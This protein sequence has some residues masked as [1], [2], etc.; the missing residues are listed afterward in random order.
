MFLEK[1]RV[2]FLYII[3]VNI[4]SINSGNKIQKRTV[5][6]IIKLFIVV[7]QTNHLTKKWFYK[8]NATIE[9]LKIGKTAGDWFGG[10]FV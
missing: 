8:F 4:N 10:E 1:E 3:K 6:Y 9:L 2:L 7:V 5:M